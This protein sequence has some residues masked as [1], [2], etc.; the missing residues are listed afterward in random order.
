MATRK[1][2]ATY[3]HCGSED[4][5]KQGRKTE[6]RLTYAKIQVVRRSTSQNRTPTRT[7]TRT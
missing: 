6:S 7:A 4:I 2:T 3:P 5:T 1:V